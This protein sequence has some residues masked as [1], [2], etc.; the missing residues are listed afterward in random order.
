MASGALLSLR[1]TRALLP[2][3]STLNH[4]ALSLYGL[5][6]CAP[7]SKQQPNPRRRRPPRQ[8]AD[9]CA[10]LVAQGSRWCTWCA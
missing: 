10:P 7:A 9:A 5:G 2:F 8:R 6:G 1:Q 3:L 4:Q